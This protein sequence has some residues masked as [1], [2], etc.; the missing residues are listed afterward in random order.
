MLKGTMHE[1]VLCVRTYIAKLE[2]PDGSVAAT[3]I[4]M[5]IWKGRLLI[6][7]TFLS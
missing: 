5:Q 1:N 7:D 6:C 3:I 2:K 4:V